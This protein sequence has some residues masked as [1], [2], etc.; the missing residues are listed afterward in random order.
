[1]IS[2]K[3]RT[4]TRGSKIEVEDCAGNK[5]TFNSVSD[6]ADA[7]KCT[8]SYVYRALRTGMKIVGCKVRCV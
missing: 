2:P 3:F 8:S 4:N 5:E 6:V 7:L 1:M